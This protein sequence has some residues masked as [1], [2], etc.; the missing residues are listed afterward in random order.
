MAHAIHPN[1]PEKHKQNHRPSMNGGVVLKINHS[2][3]YA[4]DVISASIL[5]VLA[6]KGGVKL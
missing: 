3:R 5:K 4:T 1:Y 6:Q 2:Q